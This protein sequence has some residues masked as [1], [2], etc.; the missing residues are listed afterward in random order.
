MQ[1]GDELGDVFLDTEL[2]KELRQDHKQI[3]VAVIY[4]QKV[5]RVI[6]DVFFDK[7]DVGVTYKS[8]YNLMIELNPEI[9]N[10][11]K[12]LAEYPIISK[13]FSYFRKNY[14]SNDTLTKIALVVKNDVRG[15][16]ILSVFKTP[17]LKEC[18]VVYLDSILQYYNEYLRLKHYAKNK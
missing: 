1:E 11:I 6:L 9:N 8:T 2:L 5:N 3:N 14:P 4:Q 17:E 13:N 12:I 10:K 15:K 16:Q 7:A 18:K